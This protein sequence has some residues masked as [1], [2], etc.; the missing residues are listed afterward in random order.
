MIKRE[1]IMTHLKLTQF[2]KERR[3]RYATGEL[4]VKVLPASSRAEQ[5]SSSQR[6][7]EQS[8]NDSN[9]LQFV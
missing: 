8:L 5:K 1:L 6:I 4:T 2:Q 7:L 3:Q 9:K